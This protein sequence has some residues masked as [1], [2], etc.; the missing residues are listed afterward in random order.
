[1]SGVRVPETIHECPEPGGG[2]LMPCC[3]RTPFEVPRSDR[4][5]RD[6]GNVTCG[7]GTRWS[8]AGPHEGHTVTATD[9]WEWRTDAGVLTCGRVRCS[10][11]NEWNV[12][13]WP[14]EVFDALSLPLTRDPA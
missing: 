10:C 3:G 13:G 8:G 7:W 9:V 2:G 12:S 14:T 4:M 5:T 6:P 11:G 1:M